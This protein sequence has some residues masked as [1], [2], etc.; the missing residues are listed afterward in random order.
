MHVLE[1]LSE[2]AKKDFWASLALRYAEGM[3]PRLLAKILRHYGSAF[4]AYQALASKELIVGFDSFAQK[5]P[6]ALRQAL[7]NGAWRSRAMQE[8]QDAQRTD[9]EVILWTDYRYPLA[10]KQLID[11]PVFFYTKGDVGLLSYPTLAIVGARKATVQGEQK[12]LEIAGE[13][14]SLGL[15]IVSGMALGID[16]AAHFGALA[17]EGKTIAVLGTGINVV[18]PEK[19]ADLY[20]EIAEQGLLMSEFPPFTKPLAHNFPIRN[21]LITG[22]SEGVL[23]V[24]AALKSGSLIT[25]RLALEQNKNVY[26]CRPLGINHSLGGQKLLEEGA[27]PVDDTYAIIADLVPNLSVQ[28]E[29]LRKKNV[30]ADEEAGTENPENMKKQGK[31]QK[32]L[33][34]AKTKQEEPQEQETHIYP[35]S[36]S[37]KKKYSA[38][39]ILERPK[40]DEELTPMALDFGEM[41]Q[42]IL[43]K[44]NVLKEVAKPEKIQKKKKNSLAEKPLPKQKEVQKE[45]LK[46][47]HKDKVRKEIVSDDPIVQILCSHEQLSADEILQFLRDRQIDMDMAS[48]SSAL[49]MLEVEGQIVK[50]AGAWYSL[51]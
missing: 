10:L 33:Q 25:A 43:N 47:T 23:I 4:L 28:Y 13:L 9:C 31:K 7:K 11:A 39:A 44:K 1:R 24:E 2:D 29:N 50:E 15:A 49:L 30:Q 46:E 40:I 6:S 12:A 16:Q 37:E 5:I 51:L 41:A 3:R 22:I 8:W 34:Q 17:Q 48:L 32:K 35:V 14:A 36:S 27:L 19:H 26:V 42:S 20:Q 38:H 45:I 21:R 18:Y